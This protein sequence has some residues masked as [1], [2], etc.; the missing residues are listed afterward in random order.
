MEEFDFSKNP[1]D[2]G[3]VFLAS[4]CTWEQELPASA[5][6]FES[7]FK[8]EELNSQDLEEFKQ[9]IKSIPQCYDHDKLDHALA[10]FY[11]DLLRSKRCLL[12]EHRDAGGTYYF[13]CML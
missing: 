6:K 3:A 1:F 9:F 11:H 10:S 7:H 4:A 8:K 13:A 5:L 12:K 2:Y